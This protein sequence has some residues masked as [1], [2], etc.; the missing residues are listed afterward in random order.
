MNEDQHS[1]TYLT[2]DDFRPGSSLQKPKVSLP[3]ID[4][5]KKE[6]R[7][8]LVNLLLQE[9][10]W[11]IDAQNTQDFEVTGSVFKSG[12]GRCD[13]V[14]WG[15][16][17]LPLAVVE[18][19]KTAIDFK[20]GKQQVKLYADCL[21]KMTGQRPVMYYSNGC[22]TYI[23]ESLADVPRKVSGFRTK[24]ELHL[25][26][27]RRT[28]RKNPESL[29][30]NHSILEKKRSYH[31]GAISAIRHHFNEKHRKALVALPA[32]SGKTFLTMAVIDLLIKASWVHN[33][34]FLADRSS[35]LNQTAVKFKHYL[36]DVP[37]VFAST[38]ENDRSDE[39]QIVFSTYP[40]M[41]DCL[42][43]AG[44]GCKKRFGCGYFDLVIVDEAHPAVS[45]K[46]GALFDYFDGLL[47]GFT[48]TPAPHIHRN[49]YR[50]F[51]LRD[52]TPT[53]AYDLNAA[54]AAK[55]LVPPRAMAVNISVPNTGI[56]YAKLEKNVKEEY[57]I[58]AFAENRFDGND[59]DEG[60]SAPAKSQSAA[61][62]N[63]L[64]N[65]DT[66]DRMLSHV[67]ERGQK[68]EGSLLLGKTIIF[69]LNHRHA[70]EI[71]SRFGALSPH[72]E[73]GYIRAITG[74]TAGGREL[75]NAFGQKES[76]PRIAVSVDILDSGID[77]SHLLNLVFFKPVRSRIRFM[78]MMGRGT[79]T[80]KNLLAPGKDKKYFTI[81]DFC[82]N[83][84][85]FDYHPEGV[86]VSKA[87]S[88]GGKI[89]KASLR[90]GLLLARYEGDPQ[91]LQLR[92][93]IL[94]RVHNSIDLLKGSRF[95]IR[96]KQA[97]INRC[98]DRD[99]WNDLAF[100]EILRL[101]RELAE[102]ARDNEKDERA[103]GFDLLI[104]QM[105]EALLEGN[106]TDFTVGLKALRKP[107][108]NLARKKSIP[109]IAQ[110]LPLIREMQA[111]DF[112]CNVT[113]LKLEEIR[114]TLRHWVRLTDRDT[115]RFLRTEII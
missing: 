66:I 40:T 79:R 18:T 50:L 28:V 83:Y 100:S 74:D 1:K 107:L 89:F 82:R 23:R 115:G 112:P 69:A 44:D 3:K 76:L 103:R 35:I 51:E 60:G 98:R 13:Y 37:I 61:V 54:I 86:P 21:E 97:I 84:E 57:E 4:Y 24:D 27:Q 78:H 53:F 68:I 32:G 114:E 16:N 42:P 56:T 73:D 34:L 26:I 59:F 108:R 65:T 110:C 91:L 72:L 87:E 8:Q 19:K 17:G 80:C 15:D 104:L 7:I 43:Q 25:M 109:A 105:Q 10:D 5:S 113:V 106:E 20:K 111:D 58:H 88:T 64:F 93:R 75:L 81:F 46:Y 90:V 38:G 85:Y 41:R 31:T 70:E 67:M 62:N 96:R 39:A 92:S 6:S 2:R 77:I 48:A 101:E 102:L 14:L 99:I 45:L 33:V 29:P 30:I 49:I 9:A 22:D 95:L 36:P 12:S 71:V 11:D 55:W 52:N 47:L 63:W 94:D